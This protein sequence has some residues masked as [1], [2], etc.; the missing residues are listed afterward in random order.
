VVEQTGVKVSLKNFMGNP[1]V[2]A[3]SRYL[4]Q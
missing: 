4:D 2:R 3:V 1:T